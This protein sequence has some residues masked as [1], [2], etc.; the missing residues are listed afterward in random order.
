MRKFY[1][2][3]LKDVL[4]EALSRFRENFRDNP[5]PRR[6]LEQRGIDRT[7][8]ETFCVGY[9]TKDWDSLTDWA[10]GRES[11]FKDCARTIGLLTKGKRGIFDQ[12]RDR[13]IFPVRDDS[14][15][16]VG[17]TSRSVSSLRETYRPKKFDE[18]LLNSSHSPIFDKWT[19]LLGYCEAAE[20]ICDNGRLIVAQDPV[21][22]LGLHAR[23]HR[24]SVMELIP[25]SFDRADEGSQH[26]KLM[27]RSVTLDVLTRGEE[28]ANNPD[29]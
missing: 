23:G 4:R 25:G 20:A 29:R 26:N 5:R 10:C 19:Y 16:P 18:T 28:P 22:L 13:L 14:G 6:L 12:F 7:T 24:N 9:A 1:R 21:D 17:L 15:D 2:S 8:L 27:H 3:L 11:Y